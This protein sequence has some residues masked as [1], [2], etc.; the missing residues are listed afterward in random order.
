MTNN[1]G[2][3][4]V[5]SA[6][7]RRMVDIAFRI[8]LDLGDAEDVVQEAFMRIARVGPATIDDPEGW[9]VVVTTRLSLD[10]LRSRRRRPTTTLERSREPVESEPGPAER[11]TLADG[12]TVAMHSLLGR[13]SPAERTSFVLHDVLQYSF[14]EIG[15]IV[16]RTPQACRKL[17]SRARKTLRDDAAPDR[18]DVDVV[19]QQQL[20]ERFIAACAMGDLD[21]LLSLLDPDVEGIADGLTEA[22]VGADII[23]PRMLGYLGPSTAPTLLYLP[24]GDRIGIAAVHGDEVVALVVLETRGGL[25]THI[26]A[27]LGLATRI[28]VAN[29]LGLA[30]PRTS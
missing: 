10:V 5:W 7:R 6:H 2:V 12:V 29:H 19:V 23:G 18:F 24:V 15:D 28:A 4:P 21:G 26:D 30:H 17:A 13:L 16:G 22:V 3:E 1:D 25:V 8:L 14:D 9:L 11:I 20:S 27:Q